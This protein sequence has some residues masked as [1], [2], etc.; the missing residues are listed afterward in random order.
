MEEDFIVIYKDEEKTISVS[1]LL[2]D[3]LEKKRVKKI[4]IT[5]DELSVLIPLVYTQLSANGVDIKALNKV[6]SSVAPVIT[7]G[8]R[9]CLGEP[10]NKFSNVIEM[11]SSSIDIRRDKDSFEEYLYFY[12]NFSLPKGEKIYCKIFDDRFKGLDGWLAHVSKEDLIILFWSYENNE[13]EN[14]DLLLRI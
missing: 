12:N 4:K 14:D 6:S 1:K 8:Y 2:I 13:D 9:L 11:I 5:Q 3:F 7:Y 10:Y